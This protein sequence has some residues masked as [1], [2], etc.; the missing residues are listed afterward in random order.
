[1]RQEWTKIFIIIKGE[2][3][4]LQINKTELKQVWGEY[5]NNKG[6][7]TIGWYSEDIGFGELTFVIENDGTL[8]CDNECMRDESCIKILKHFFESA[9]KDWQIIDGKCVYVRRKNNVAVSKD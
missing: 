7:F 6:G 1:M 3:V 2:F 5:E 9:V 4:N 8:R